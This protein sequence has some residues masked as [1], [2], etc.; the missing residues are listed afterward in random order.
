M[1]MTGRGGRAEV[2][3]GA[4]GVRGCGGRMRM[5]DKR[6]CVWWSRIVRNVDDLPGADGLIGLVA[7]GGGRGGKT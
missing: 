4:G 5:I 3:R 2:M 1:G 7:V 6:G